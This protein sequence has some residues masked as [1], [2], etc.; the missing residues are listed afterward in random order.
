MQYTENLKIKLTP[1]LFLVAF[2]FS[3]NIF[4]FLPFSKLDI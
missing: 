4:L 2:S 1:M 3:V